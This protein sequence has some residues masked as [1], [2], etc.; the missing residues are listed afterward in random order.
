MRA[1]LQAR[2][3]DTGAPA[4]VV[5][6]DPS[7]GLVLDE[8][9]SKRIVACCV[10][11]TQDVMVSAEDASALAALDVRFPVAVKIVSPDIAHK[12][13]V[14]GVV[15]DVRN[16]EALEAAWET[17]IANARRHRP[18]ARLTGVLVSEMV[19]DGVEALIGVVDDAVFGP[20]VAC[21]MGG[22]LAEVLHDVSYRVA[23]FDEQEARDMIR[24]LRTWP[25]F[26][27]VRGK[28]PADVAALAQ[29]LVRVARF[30]W[31]GRDKVAEVDINPLLV[32]PVARTAGEGVIAADALVVLRQAS[33]AQ[34]RPGRGAVSDG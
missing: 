4:P 6:A 19:T 30:A 18:Q 32:R 9:Q 31:H 10:S 28:P 1:R 3:S 21:G 2:R 20:V 12:T 5:D 33:T 17:V 34:P 27:G 29:A 22:T 8:M 11:V 25:V 26:E 23:P 15:L 16:R 13:D 24:E 7:G 14:G